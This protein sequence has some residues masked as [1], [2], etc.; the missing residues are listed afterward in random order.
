[1]VSRILLR[2]LRRDLSRQRWQFLATTL[3]IGIGIA[4]Y[5]AATDA[6]ANLRQSFD[7]AYAVQLLPDA[8]ISGPGASGLYE[9]AR[10]LPGSPAVELRQ[11]ADVGIRINGHTLFGR[12]VSV[13]VGG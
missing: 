9:A 10:A 6:Y 12:A 5:V 11:Q 4:V 8:V 3:V 2:K 13:P 7:R 1:M